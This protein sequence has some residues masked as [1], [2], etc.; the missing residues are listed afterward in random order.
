MAL[1]TSFINEVFIQTAV[2]STMQNYP[3]RAEHEAY[4]PTIIDELLDTIQ[5]DMD[6]LPLIND[7]GEFTPEFIERWNY[8]IQE[9]KWTRLLM[10]PEYFGAIELYFPSSMDPITMKS[11]YTNLITTGRVQEFLGPKEVLTEEPIEV[12]TTDYVEMIDKS[13]EMGLS[14]DTILKTLLNKHMHKYDTMINFMHSTVASTWIN[15]EVGINGNTEGF[16]GPEKALE[17]IKTAFLNKVIKAYENSSKSIAVSINNNKYL[18]VNSLPQGTNRI[19]ES[20]GTNFYSFTSMPNIIF[21]KNS[22]ITNEQVLINAIEDFDGSLAG[23]IKYNTDIKDLPIIDFSG[24]ISDK[25]YPI[26]FARLIHNN[27]DTFIKSYYPQLSTAADNIRTSHDT[28]S[29][30][31]LASDQESASLKMHKITTPR[32]NAPRVTIGG[33]VIGLSRSVDQS[34]LN[35][36]DYDNISRI[37]RK[38]AIG[39]K[40]LEDFKDS[41]YVFMVDNTKS[42]SDR[43][44]IA[45][46]YYRFFSDTDY[47]VTGL[48]KDDGTTYNRTF[49]SYTSISK[50][51]RVKQGLTVE[52]F[53]STEDGAYTPNK[54]LDNVVSELLRTFNSTVDQ[55]NLVSTNGNLQKTNSVNY[56]PL[57]NIRNSLKSAMYYSENAGGKYITKKSAFTDRL[58]VVITHNSANNTHTITVSPRNFNTKQVDTTQAFSYTYTIKRSSSQPVFTGISTSKN[59]ITALELCKI[60]SAAGVS[61]VL[62]EP[63]FY[64]ALDTNTKT[65]SVPLSVEVAMGYLLTLE[66]NKLA[67]SNNGPNSGLTIEAEVKTDDFDFDPINI[68]HPYKEMMSRAYTDV[69]GNDKRVYALDHRGVRLALQKVADKL[70]RTL[71]LIT[72]IKKS[73]TNINKNSLLASGRYEFKGMYNKTGIKVGDAIKNNANMSVHEQMRYLMEQAFLHTSSFSDFRTALFQQ[74][75]M[76]D[77]T[78]IPVSEIRAVSDSDS[79]MPILGNNLDVEKL[80]IDFKTSQKAYW[81]NLSNE[82]INRWKK[83]LPNEL[84]YFNGNIHE[85]SEKVSK[86]NIPFDEFKATSG[87]V[88]NSMLTSRNIEGTKM[89]V[90]AVP[91]PLVENIALFTYETNNNLLEEFINS[92]LETFK[93]NLE[94]M[95]YKTLTTKSEEILSKRF[96]GIPKD[97]QL[98][99]LATGFFY[100][101]STL[102]LELSSMH[103]GGFIQ[104]KLDGKFKHLFN[105]MFMGI[106]TE[107]TEDQYKTSLLDALSKVTINNKQLTDTTLTVEEVKGTKNTQKLFYY[108]VLNNP[109]LTYKDKLTTLM[110]DEINT[111]SSVQFID[112]LKRNALLGSGIQ[113]PRLEDTYKPGVLLGKSSKNIVYQDLREKIAIVGKGL[114]DIDAYDAVQMALPI[115]FVKLGY[116][117]GGDETPYKPKGGAV[118]DLTV[119]I[120]EA[121]TY[122]GQKKATFN[123][124][125]N[126]FL[127]KGTNDLWTI[128]NKMTTAIKFGNVEVY[129]YPVEDGEDVVTVNK[130]APFT[131]PITDVIWLANGPNLGLMSYFDGTKEVIVD[132]LTIYNKLQKDLNGSFAKQF[133]SDLKDGKYKTNKIP[134]TFDNIREI[135]EYFGSINNETV[136]ESVAE[137]ICN[138]S[139]SKTGDI[140][141][142]DCDYPLRNAYIEKVGATTQE[143]TGSTN[144][145]TFNNLMDPNYGF[146]DEVSG[147]NRFSEVGNEGHGVILQ[148][149]HNP[150]TTEGSH[151]DNEADAEDPNKINMVTQLL[152]SLI[153]EGNSLAETVRTYEAM[154]LL[155][156]IYVDGERANFEND[157]RKEL[158]AYALTRLLEKYTDEQDILY[159]T[160]KDSS[161]TESRKKAIELDREYFRL[162]ISLEKYFQLDIEGN[163]NNPTKLS[164]A[165]LVDSD[166]QIID[167]IVRKVNNNYLLDIVKRSLQSK[168][169]GGSIGELIISKSIEEISLDLKQVLPLATSAL[170]AEFNRNTVRQKFPGGQYVVSPSH[171]LLSTYT[172]NG[173]DGYTRDQLNKIFNNTDDITDPLYEETPLV[174]GK[175]QLSDSVKY[176]GEQQIEGLVTGAYYPLS[177][178]KRKGV[179]DDMLYNSGMFVYRLANIDSNANNLKWMRYYKLASD[180][181]KIEVKTTDE[182]KA[183]HNINTIVKSINDPSIV[184]PLIDN[185]IILKVA[186]NNIVNGANISTTGYI[187]TVLPESLLA[188]PDGKYNLVKSFV[189]ANIGM[190]FKKFFESILYND[191]NSG[192][193][194][195]DT[196][197]FY[198]PPMHQK[199]FLISNGDT[200]NGILGNNRPDYNMLLLHN[201]ITVGT[202]YTFNKKGDTITFFTKEDIVR[203]AKNNH[204]KFNY[205]LKNLVE[206]EGKEEIINSFIANYK[207][208]EDSMKSYFTLKVE[209]TLEASWN[210]LMNEEEPSIYIENTLRSYPNM[211]NYVR[212]MFI[213]VNNFL[214]NNKPVYKTRKLKDGT[215]EYIKDKEDNNI[216][217]YDSMETVIKYVESKYKDKMVHDL[218]NGFESS[219]DFINARIPAPAKQT[220]NAATIKDFIFDT[221]NSC[222]GPLEMLIMTGADHDIDKQNMMTWHYSS[223]GEFLDWYEFLDAEGKISKE[224]FHAVLSSK[225]NS[226]EKKRFREEF[227]KRVQNFVIH[228]MYSILKDP[229]N[230]IE[231]N[232]PTSMDTVAS[233]KVPVDTSKAMETKTIA[234][235][236]K[237]KKLAL[238]YNPY[239]TVEY[240]KIN[241]DGKGGIGI[242]ASDLKA[243]FAT[244]YA[245]ATTLVNGKVSNKDKKY[246][247]FS[248]DL[249]NINYL[250]AAT[251]ENKWGEIKPD[252][253]QYF[254]TRT[255][256]LK[257]QSETIANTRK[258]KEEYAKNLADVQT[259]KNILQKYDLDNLLSIPMDIDTVLDEKD[260]DEI[261]SFYVQPEVIKGED[262]AAVLVKETE[263]QKQAIKNWYTQRQVSILQPYANQ[264]KNLDTENVAEQAWE[265]LAELLAAATDNAKELILG[266]INATSM[267][268]SIISTMVR[269]G[270]PLKYA[271]ELVGDSGNNPVQTSLGKISNIRELVKAVED[272][273]D[274]AKGIKEGYTLTKVLKEIVDNLQTPYTPEA[275]ASYLKNPYRQLY[276]FS[277]ISDEFSILSKMLSINQ[278]LKNSTFDVNHF[279]HT[280]EDKINIKDF[281]LSR[282]VNELGKSKSDY[283][284]KMI[285]KYNEKKEGINILYILSKNSHYIGY[286]RGM[287]AAKRRVDSISKVN[288]SV[289]N[290]I[291]RL[292]SGFI[293]KSTLKQ[294]EFTKLQNFIYGNVIQQYISAKHGVIHLMGKDFDLTK[295][296]QEGIVGGRLEFMLY[297]PE[298][299]N[300]HVE[301]MSAESKDGLYHNDFLL[302]LSHK[303]S[304]IDYVTQLQI[305]TIEGPI[306]HNLSP[307]RQA[308]IEV[309]VNQLRVENKPLHDA[310]FLYTLIATRGSYSGGS[311]MVFYPEEFL[312]FSKFV[313][314]KESTNSPLISMTG[315]VDPSNKEDMSTIAVVK[316]NNPF[317]I[318]AYGTTTTD[319]I[320][321]LKVDNEQYSDDNYDKDFDFNE[322]SYETFDV[323]EYDDEQT[324]R[325]KKEWSE[326]NAELFNI[327]GLNAL[328]NRAGKKLEPI[329]RSKHTG[330]RYVW[331][332]TLKTYIP[333]TQIIPEVCISNT[334]STGIT[335]ISDSG[336][337]AGWKIKTKAGEGSLIAFV[338]GSNQSNTSLIESIQGRKDIPGI[339][340]IGKSEPCYLI[341]LGGESYTI[342]TKDEIETYNT[343]NIIKLEGFKFMKTSKLPIDKPIPRV[344]LN[345][346]NNIITTNNTGKRLDLAITEV[347]TASRVPVDIDTLISKIPLTETKAIL[348]SIK[349]SLGQLA[350][351]DNR[352]VS[353]MFNKHLD[354]LKSMTNIKAILPVL[355]KL[356]GITNLRSLI[357]LMN[358]L[359]ISIADTDSIVKPIIEKFLD[360]NKDITVVKY[361]YRNDE[362]GKEKAIIRSSTAKKSKSIA[363]GFIPPKLREMFVTKASPE[364]VTKLVNYIQDMLPNTNCLLLST[365]EIRNAYGESFVNDD[366][367]AFTLNGEIILNMD[368][369]TI[370]TPIHEFG[371]VYIQYLKFEDNPLYNKI[372]TDALTHPFAKTVRQTY[373]GLTEEEV[374]E[375]VFVHLLSG[376]ATNIVNN[377]NEYELVLQYTSEGGDLI[378][379]IKRF[380][381]K[382]FSE[383]FG[384]EVDEDL[385]SI[386]DSLNTIIS[387]VGNSIVYG[388]KSLFN[389][390]SKSTK[391]LV[392][393]SNGRK[394]INY[395][396]AYNLLLERGFIQRVCI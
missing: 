16:A 368:R 394:L 155:S 176:I 39:S 145:I 295:N 53:L 349:G 333:Y 141:L 175:V 330:L 345:V 242:F 361:E 117:L 320:K 57:D 339:E 390:I 6:S 306:I 383:L 128:F 41:L 166:K 69:A 203:Y 253:I 153:A 33:N 338:S 205:I 347:T 140:T 81:N 308:Q 224:K 169:G 264:L 351:D 115:Y 379:K 233:A 133:R 84:A 180:G 62:I 364:M 20:V 45:S 381:E 36:L 42:E 44:L 190:D 15:Q 302:N 291:E 392:D 226:K 334:V 160:G 112:Q 88:A 317:F 179:T 178:I 103:T 162:D 238:P 19:Q 267:T 377:N 151:L 251:P 210:V 147:F 49:R 300:K 139:L 288:Q 35:H 327:N 236:L 150:D 154:G 222:Y 79:F 47:T 21:V 240:E 237:T 129:V 250:E 367:K 168:G 100:H 212:S 246:T 274:T 298:A 28:E 170:N 137:V 304:K 209:E 149:D 96:K 135:W 276:N 290:I 221:R 11:D 131:T 76:S 303:N 337:E 299:I 280:I 74:G 29:T 206:I 256:N 187:N 343:E 5:Y 4:L 235:T 283:V 219:L 181:T 315:S 260:V 310:L 325:K 335:K 31:I 341:A 258:F 80:R 248:S 27:F 98:D 9:L 322:D 58:H 52:E 239:T 277:R 229:K 22:E 109:N 357:D 97:K 174:P 374:G 223:T 90:A 385:I 142:K 1:C 227:K 83:A 321:H 196:A 372:V 270:I 163:L 177:Y 202:P 34:Y 328:A 136:W 183:F 186:Y 366:V 152:S 46:I 259:A 8:A 184:L 102:A 376:Y 158:D 107:A 134:K 60:L 230:A 218:V 193:Y 369:V 113:S 38:N 55:E 12:V 144:V 70:S 266:Q 232:T 159:L 43:S 362:S 216:L 195:S 249:N 294:E 30:P 192:N 189:V 312:S 375:E 194:T 122:K 188:D 380:F 279:I 104:F 371:H 200:V 245:Y 50:E 85:L 61:G 396:Y 292:T 384:I 201:V 54:Q 342:M 120:D 78:T 198:M 217:L 118:K 59:N 293:S 365:E 305:P 164:E 254:D 211:N 126:E 25:D 86:L 173:K 157:V 77:R 167:T 257:A 138:A 316:L 213:L 269:I 7:S 143:K 2:L 285:E 297:L 215:I 344:I 387:K 72:N 67:D 121:G 119:A 148:P 65:G 323:S 373:S 48:T 346:D 114:S 395:D 314:S 68:M 241:M 73:T 161:I 287:F 336:F 255:G 108:S 360:E 191:L 220:G 355:V 130:K 278:G 63:K 265:N 93:L 116:S 275:T 284:D 71:N 356:Q 326:T 247:R 99:L 386:H 329:I 354:V 106:P 171:K 391:D 92:N 243:Y 3:S 370:D 185:E 353:L 89:Q 14:I 199:R 348:Q 307:E 388:D 319:R 358:T 289:N 281:N 182:L 110:L 165:G 75:V 23:S 311:F 318:P 17:R 91:V 378:A 313:K 37:L 350:K 286:Y 127:R 231:V 225:R 13:I 382:I 18:V 262:E 273:K 252:A 40:S 172:F 94:E 393:M 207:A 124:F 125:S 10:F 332:N 123:A 197:E 101:W 146:I 132:S 324:Y 363:D 228:N 24:E 340:L 268:S 111:T 352:N 331:N 156:D 282:F 309:G 87:L 105:N 272:T 56:G 204:D 26:A 82:T 271:L 234:S 64:M 301:T 66:S 244:M 263:A 208:T 95:G 32:L 214:R 389:N 261:A 51:N 296:S 359:E